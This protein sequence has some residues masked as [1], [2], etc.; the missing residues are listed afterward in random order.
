MIVEMPCC[1]LLYLIEP[2]VLL[3]IFGPGRAE[4]TIAYVRRLSND[5]ERENGRS[6]SL[7]CD[8]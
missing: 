8:L 6:A 4:I 3:M 1:K 7:V 2:T 5:P